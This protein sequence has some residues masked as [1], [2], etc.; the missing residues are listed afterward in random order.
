MSVCACAPQV[1]LGIAHRLR[2]LAP[3]KVTVVDNSAEMLAR[4]TKLGHSAVM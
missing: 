2:L 1:G 3:G 4:A